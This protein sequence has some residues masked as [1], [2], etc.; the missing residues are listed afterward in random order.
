MPYHLMLADDDEAITEGLRHAI[1]DHYPD[2][3]VIHEATSGNE[4]MELLRVYPAS[5]IIT[6]IKMP[7]ID[8]LQCLEAIREMGMPCE[9]VFLSGFDDYSLI[10]KALKLSAY[11]YLLKPVH[12]DSL[13]RIIRDL[14]PRLARLSPKLASAPQL[15]ETVKAFAYF[16]GPPAEH[17]L[18][19]EELKG[20]LDSL[21]HAMQTMDGAEVRLSLDAF[22]SGYSPAVWDEQTVKAA[23]VECI[24][25]LMERI[26]A[27]IRIIGDLKLTEF[28]A[29]NS[30]RNLPTFSQLHCQLRHIM[31]LYL[32]RLE[33]R[34]EN[35]MQYQIR[36]AKEY[37]HRHY[38]EN[39]VLDALAGEL[40][41]SPNY[42]SALFKQCTNTT[43]RDYL[44]T[45]RIRESMRLIQEGRLK[46]YEIAEKV[47][48]Q[49]ASHFNRAFKEVA[50]V[51]P[52]VWAVHHK[53]QAE[54]APL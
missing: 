38:A 18:G 49:N 19:P 43:F 44:R 7:G 47:G 50:G 46:L 3:F 39:L 6:D 1:E 30:I 9:V 23:L 14:L 28:D 52:S 54:S 8:G 25:A 27:M 13:I 4:L 31:E 26:P 32:E 22:F 12:I 16:D 42:F 51:T 53:A 37:I 36:R 24:S 15:P 21:V 2:T 11:D 5:L 35:R 34:T 10:R 20:L 41:M 40:F 45:V 29:V 48:Y 33:Q 17:P